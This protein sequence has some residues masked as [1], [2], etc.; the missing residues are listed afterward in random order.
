MFRGN[1]DSMRREW[2]RSAMAHN[3]FSSSMPFFQ[4]LFTSHARYETLRRELMKMSGDALNC[5]KQAIFALHRDDV[6]VAEERLKQARYQ[7]RLLGKFFKKEPDLRGEGS[8]RAALEEYIEA[9]FYARI[10]SGKPLE[11]LAEIDADTDSYLGGVCDLMG[12]M[13]RKVVL[14]AT[15]RDFD[16]VKKLSR[17]AESMMGE[18]VRFDLTGYLR[19]KYD[20][21]KQAMRR[22][23]EI[24]YDASK[25]DLSPPDSYHLV[26]DRKRV[27]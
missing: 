23:E 10:L 15:A 13:A 3:F 16:A 9:V 24:A 12:E 22:I 2:K 21:A 1:F 5:A 18:L 27:A 26:N 11:I 4:N 19:N 6:V 7:F 17:E 20:Q 25:T 14:L 8:Y